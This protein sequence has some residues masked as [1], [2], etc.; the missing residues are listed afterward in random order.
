MGFSR[1]PK[2]VTDG[3]VLALD[4]AN[5]K[6]YPGSGTTWSDLSGNGNNGSLINGPT[7]DSGNNGS[8]VFDGVDD[9][10]STGTTP[11]ELLGN[12]SFT[13]SM[14]VKR[15]S[16]EVT[17]TGIW[18]LG[19]NT[20]NQGIN[21]WW[22]NNAN[23][24]TIDTWGQATFTTGVTYP[25]NEWVFVTW[26]K[27]AGDMTRA[28]CILWRNLVSFTGTQL[29]IIRAENVA[30]NINNLGLS[31]ARISTTY[32]VPVNFAFSN[33]GLYNRIL[34]PEEIHQNYNATKSRFG[35]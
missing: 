33:T 25:L 26:Q 6:S 16:N 35:L 9:Y 1:G 13:L 30:P 31:I 7:F 29:S 2:I 22:S 34:T 21:S 12:P 3:L 5:P 27:I 10:F 28:N 15:L 11:P 20:I 24:I 8:I 32:N 18:G 17:N 23:E 19:G 4:A 14:W